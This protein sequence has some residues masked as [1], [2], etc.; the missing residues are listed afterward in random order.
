MLEISFFFSKRDHFE[1][2]CCQSLIF[3]VLEQGCGRK[4][5]STG[6]VFWG[7]G[8][9]KKKEKRQDLVLKQIIRIKANTFPRKPLAMANKGKV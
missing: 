8:K 9:L 2:Q 6:G 5:K 1:E 7:V 4:S 3:L